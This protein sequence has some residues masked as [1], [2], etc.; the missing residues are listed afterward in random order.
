MAH[1]RFISKDSLDVK[2]EYFTYTAKVRYVRDHP[3][4][5]A[6]SRRELNPV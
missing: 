6:L 3:P 1:L 4:F 2:E 5:G